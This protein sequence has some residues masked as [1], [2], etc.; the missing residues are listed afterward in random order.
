VRHG[1]YLQPHPR[2]DIFALRD[3]GFDVDFICDSE[4][5][6]PHLEHVDGVTVIRLPIRHKRGH[7]PRYLFEYTVMPVLAAGALALRSVWRRYD[8][9]E[10]DTMPTWLIA[11]AVVPKLFGAKVVLY[12]FE[13]MAELTA[14]DKGLTEHHRLI[15]L[16]DRIE[17]ACV[18]S[19]DVVLTPAERNRE[20]YISRR[21]APQKIVFIPNCPDERMF[22]AN[23]DPV[24]L[25]RLAAAGVAVGPTEGNA[26]D[27]DRRS[28]R[29][30]PKPANVFRLVTHGSLLERY[31]IQILI[32][33]VANL[34]GKHSEARIPGIKLD[35]IGSGEYESELMELAHKLSLDETV[36]FVGLVPFEEMA[37]HLLEADVGVGPYL[38]DLLPNKMM[39][40]LLLG[41][42]AIASD[43][44]TMRRYFDDDVVTYVPPNDVEA[45]AS[46]IESMYRHP[47]KRKRQADMAQ[48][49]YLG[50]LAWSKTKHHYLAVYGVEK[51]AVE[52]AKKGSDDS[53]R[54][55]LS[56]VLGQSRGPRNAL[57]RLPTIATR[58]GLSARKSRGH[59]EELLSVTDRYG[60]RPTLPVTAVTARRHPELVRWLQDR[61]VEVAA[62]GYVH[63]DYKSISAV[64]QL[65]QVQRA[66]DEMNSLG[67][68]VRGWRCP[69]SRWNEDTMAALRRTGFEYDATPVYEWPAFDQENIVMSPEARADYE[70]LCKLYSVQ[71]AGT[72]AVLPHS[73]DGLVQIPMSI[74]QDED[75]VDRLHLRPDQ[76]S[77]V[78]LRVLTETR[79]LGELF[80]VCLHPE[81]ARLC[82][83][84]L[85]AILCEAR[86]AGDVWIA[87][88]GDIADWWLERKKATIR[89][90]PNGQD[91]KWRLISDASRRS[92][93]AMGEQTLRGAGSLDISSKLK[94]AVFAGTGWPEATIARVA[95]A[96]YIV[97]NNGIDRALCAARLG[98]RFSPSA[99]PDEIVRWLGGHD[100]DLARVLPWPSR[101]GQPGFRSCLSITGDVDAI[102]L[103]DF[104]LRLKEFS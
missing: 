87:P 5:G 91:G 31:G 85:D 98:D 51:L 52:S 73:S 83:E 64:E 27:H 81:R 100:R 62:H 46:A 4:P 71:D 60:V 80:V 11:A 22:L 44:P 69:Y 97:E 42:P 10:I 92:V 1:D 19:A 47:R 14:S 34:R 38:L 76:M 43:W 30:N 6:R 95:E 94:P 33:A 78:W 2:R 3:A 41:I 96:G 72:R 53:S 25:R 82:R 86:R 63:N 103:F 28:A 39:E 15:R 20:L 17:I 65:N 84:P 26:T 16:L 57:T 32:E 59:F 24:S 61:G 101:A 37:S 13:H 18:R 79:Q 74:P 90:E 50:T 12:M 54:T 70:R 36:R 67:F 66:R 56:F 93:T 29:D 9:V 77:R 45:L 48:A 58:F 49:R 55:W 88:L 7:L 68:E 102:T 8:Y 21:V 23:V 104:A 35:V 75:M 89:L 40:Y 99:H